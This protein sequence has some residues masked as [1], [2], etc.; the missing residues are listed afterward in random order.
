MWADLN[1]TVAA[2]AGITAAAWI[3]W[4]GWR[5]SSWLLMLAV[6]PIGAW[7]AVLMGHRL[8]FD[9]QVV[10][11]GGLLV[12]ASGAC[13]LVVSLRT[14]PL[15][16]RILTAS[17]MA[18][19]LFLIVEFVYSAGRSP[20]GQVGRN[21]V[22][23]CAGA[24][25]FIAFADRMVSERARLQESLR[26]SEVR[27]HGLAETAR[28]LIS[29][30]EPSGR[31][32][33]VSPS[34]RTL[35]GYAPDELIGRDPYEVLVH[36]DDIPVVTEEMHERV[37][38]GA[39]YAEGVV[40]LRRKS[41]EYRWF[42]LH[43]QAVRGTDGELV[44]MR[45]SSRDIS[46]RKRAEDKLRQSQRKLRAL[47]A[48][49]LEQEEEVHRRLA[50]EIHDDLSQRL[51]VIRLALA[52]LGE[53]SGSDS[54]IAQ[55]LAPVLDGMDRLSQDMQTMARGLHP[56]TIDH[57]GLVAALKMHC[58]A[59][60]ETDGIPVSFLHDHVPRSLPQ[61]LSTCFYRVA[62]EA[63]RN[64]VTHSQAER[65]SVSLTCEAA[66]LVLVV[67]D[68]G[69]GIDPDGAGE[70]VGLGLVSMEER[71]RAIDGTLSIETPPHGGTRIRVT[72][73]LPAMTTERPQA[74]SAPSSQAPF[75]PPAGISPH[76]N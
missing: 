69:V 33:Y 63:L 59:L 45:A 34:S 36:P 14:M 10:F 52:R 11:L 4:L 15:R 21:M 40:R 2:L 48:R 66:T 55:R 44:G 7:V 75:F 16:L 13:L 37:L 39:D 74:S 67:E 24:L 20:D 25:V 76:R 62:Q 49:L 60:V 43:G 73:S 50:R 46:K 9:A 6:A 18:V 42:E 22:T 31:V 70:R 30:H 29:F 38:N 61:G 19:L 8:G 54:E 64:A 17:I 58:A 41:G 5:A 26:Q 72:K 32:S 71:I 35:L 56:S 47:T 51:M 12:V 65:I 57:L 28:D 27:Y 23:V 68:R 1:H 53:D 3:L